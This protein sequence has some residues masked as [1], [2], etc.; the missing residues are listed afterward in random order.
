VTETLHITVESTDEFHEQ[1]LEDLEAIERGDDVDDAHV[2]SLPSKAELSRLFSEKNIQLLQVIA[3][4]E[5]ASMREAARFVDRDV[6]EVSRNL[7]ELES[8]GVIEFEKDGRAKRPVVWYDEL[9]I[10][11]PLRTTDATDVAA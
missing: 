10:S 6:K 11:V 4:R 5:P 9:D 1:V 7:H 2:L 8:L 3:E